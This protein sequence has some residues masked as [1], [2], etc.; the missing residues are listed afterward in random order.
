L[1]DIVAPDPVLTL[2]ADAPTLDISATSEVDSAASAIAKV[3][4]KHHRHRFRHK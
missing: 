3:R 1:Q 2:E 4:P